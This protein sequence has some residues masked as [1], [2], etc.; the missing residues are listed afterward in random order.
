MATPDLD[1]ARDFATS[2]ALHERALHVLP[3]GIAHDSRHFQPFPVYVERAQ[4][5]HKWT[6]DGRELIDLGMGH[7][8]L[9]LGH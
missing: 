2:E 6:A 8:A 1:F 3:S 4:G 5:S 7:G 9:V